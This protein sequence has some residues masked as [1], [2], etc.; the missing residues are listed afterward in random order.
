[1]NEEYTSAQKSE[2]ELLEELIAVEK[3]N[4]IRQ[5]ILILVVA[6]L[7][8]VLVVSAAM[9][10]PKAVKTIDTV[11]SV[12]ESIED[13]MDDIDHMVKSA[14]ELIDSNMDGVAEALT[15]INEIDIDTLN[16]SIEDFSTVLQSL[17]K[18]ANLFK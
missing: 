18:I 15:K 8:V 17:S 2:S 12:V 11:N 9:V 5:T 1:M 14:G 7:T 6:A 16:S 4:G 3:R 13:S 10:I